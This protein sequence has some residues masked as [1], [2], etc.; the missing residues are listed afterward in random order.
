ME[1]TRQ[2]IESFGTLPEGW[3]FGRGTNAPKEVVDKSLAIL[4]YGENLGCSTDAF[5]EDE[6]N[7]CIEFCRGDEFVD[8]YINVDGTFALCHE[9]GIG[10]EYDELKDENPISRDDALTY[11]ESFSKKPVE[12]LNESTT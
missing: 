11:L 2:K 8:I 3:N 5:P 1:T 7:I 4:E 12:V 9:K 10:A 6:G